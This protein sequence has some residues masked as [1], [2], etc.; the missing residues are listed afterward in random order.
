MKSNHVYPPLILR[1]GGFASIETQLVNQFAMIEDVPV[2][3]SALDRLEDHV[4]LLASGETLPVGSVEFVRRAMAL[5]GIEEP[6][7]LTYPEPLQRFLLRDVKVQRAGSVLGTHFVK[8]LKTKEFTGFVFDSMAD[9][10]S[11]SPHDREQYDA[12]MLLDADEP[13]WVR[14]HQHIKS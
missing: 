12:F 14:K 11:L 6:A 7:N 1:Q 3:T 4:E 13:V 8:P 5:A 2:L 10:S 9:P